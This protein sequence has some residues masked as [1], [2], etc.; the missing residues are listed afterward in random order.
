[1]QIFFAGVLGAAKNLKYAGRR[2]GPVYQIGAKPS[3]VSQFLSLFFCEYGPIDV[4]NHRDEAKLAA[5]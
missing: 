3:H 1:M 5:A 2:F 4:W